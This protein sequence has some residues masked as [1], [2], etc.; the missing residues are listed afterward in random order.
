MEG[1][2]AQQFDVLFKS[3][4]I[5]GL[6]G[7][8]LD[9]YSGFWLGKRYRFTLFVSDVLFGVVAA[10]MTFFGALVVTDG[11]LHPVLVVGIVCGCVAEHWLIGRWLAA[12]FFRMHCVWR[13]SL[14]YSKRFLADFMGKCVYKREKMD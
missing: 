5:G 1:Y 3:V 9:A 7:I 6:I 2:E 12:L 13:S 14:C 8:L 4:I 11:Y 10:M